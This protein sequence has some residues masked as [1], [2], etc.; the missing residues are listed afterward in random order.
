M[1][2]PYQIRRDRAEDGY[3]FVLIKF[4]A[5]RAVS[6]L[7]QAEGL[8]PPRWL[9]DMQYRLNTESLVPQGK[10]SDPNPRREG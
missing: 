5:G 6:R 9:T 7:A 2:G 3:R 1:R 8:I 10:S 4:K